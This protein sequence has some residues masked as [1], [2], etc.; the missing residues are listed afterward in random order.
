VV[1]IFIQTFSF[2]RV[3]ATA[4][5][6]DA[7]AKANRLRINTANYLA[8]VFFG[9]PLAL[10]MIYRIINAVRFQCMQFGGIWKSR[11]WGY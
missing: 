6:A 5:I 10:L 9:M 11:C 2:V 4:V 8:F 1:I 7:I 3:K